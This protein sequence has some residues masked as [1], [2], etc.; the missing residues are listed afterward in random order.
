M[1]IVR[2]LI[3]L[4]YWALLTVLLLAPNPAAVVGLRKVPTFPW[5]DMGMHFTAFAILT[6]IVNAAR[7]PRCPGRFIVVLLLVYGIAAE[8]LQA[9]ISPRAVDM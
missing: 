7:W 9:F 5:G 8:S 4:G 6:L 1:R 2:L 3:C